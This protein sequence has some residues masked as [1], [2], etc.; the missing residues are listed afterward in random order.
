MELSDLQQQQ[1]EHDSTYWDNGAEQSLSGQLLMCA[2]CIAGESGEFAGIA[3]K[4]R[5]KEEGCGYPEYDNREL[6]KEVR[7][8]LVDVFIYTLITANVLGIDIEREYQKKQQKNIERHQD[9]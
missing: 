2:V 5:L 8:E 7:E 4:I 6:E 9:K 1:K 3:K